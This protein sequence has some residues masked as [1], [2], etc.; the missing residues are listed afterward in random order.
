MDLPGGAVVDLKKMQDEGE[1]IKKVPV[2]D[3]DIKRLIEHLNDASVT[4]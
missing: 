3:E 1:V 2:S 4:L